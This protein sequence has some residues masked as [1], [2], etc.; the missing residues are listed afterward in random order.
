MRESL[1]L[2]NGVIMFDGGWFLW[3]AGGEGVDERFVGARRNYGK[4]QFS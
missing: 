3:D 1:E 2:L 4:K